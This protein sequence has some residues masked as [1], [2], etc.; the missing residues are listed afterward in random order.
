MQ[1]I[2]SILSVLATLFCGAATLRADANVVYQE[3]DGKIIEISRGD[4][5]RFKGQQGIK[6]ASVPDET[7]DLAARGLSTVKFSPSEKK[8]VTK[9]RKEIDD[10]KLAHDLAVDVNELLAI[11]ARILAARDIALREDLSTALFFEIEKA[12]SALIEKFDAI[13]AKYEE[14]K[15]K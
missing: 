7:L 12:H 8:V 2:I 11:N 13:A 10:A 14:G 1:T 3:S 9:T 4:V 5:S 6:I 15:T